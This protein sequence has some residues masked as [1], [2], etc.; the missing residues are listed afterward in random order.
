MLWLWIIV[1]AAF[2]A[3]VVLHR[4]TDA[5]AVR[6]AVVESAG[7]P[8]SGL[9]VTHFDVFRAQL[10]PTWF[11]LGALERCETPA[12]TGESLDGLIKSAEGSFMYMELDKASGALSEAKASLGCLS[13]PVDPALAARIGFLQGVVSVE[14]G[15]KAKAWEQFSFA[16][17]FAPEL[18]WDAQFPKDG[19]ALLRASSGELKSSAAVSVGLVPASAAASVMVNGQPAIMERESL[20]LK[21]GQNLLQV[22]NTEGWTGYTATIEAQSSP[23]LFL[24]G[25][26]SDDT[27]SQVSTDG[28][29]RALSQMV[30]L[31]FE[32]GTPVYVVHDDELWRTASGLG[33]WED[34]RPAQSPVPG[35]KPV[36]LRPVAWVSAGLT[37]AAAIGTVSALLMGMNAGTSAADSDRAFNEAASRGDFDGA[38][39]AHTAS[40]QSGNRKTVGYA[41]AGVGAA[42]TVTGVVIT[43]P[44]FKARR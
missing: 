38:S 36:G 12:A 19:E 14:L 28:G 18:Q 25:A 13:E 21:P 43:I 6:A 44:M 5:D 42:L 17:R 10:Q 37:T 2:A 26:L 31:A 34:L 20:Q 11:G 29:R 40:I 3:P 39:S 23:S 35:P 16:A 1:N 32:S 27:L 30:S 24:P 15:D 33:V 9:T 7:V 41:A 4:E 22:Q 8:V